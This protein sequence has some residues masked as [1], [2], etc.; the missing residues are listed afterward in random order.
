MRG[1][2]ALMRAAPKLYTLSLIVASA[3][4]LVTGRTT[5]AV[6]F[7]GAAVLAAGVAVRVAL[8]DR[9]Q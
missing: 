2:V 6:A 8:L 3:G 9:R 5:Q 4:S 7:G 1:I